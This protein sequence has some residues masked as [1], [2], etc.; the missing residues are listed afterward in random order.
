MDGMRFHASVSDH[1]A[2]HE[3]IKS[4]I[5]DAGAALKK[6][7]VAFVFFTGHHRDEATELAERLWLELDPQCIVG[8]SAEGVIGGD[9]E[10]ERAP[11]ISL[12]VGELPGVTI[13]PFHIGPDDWR[14]L[15]L[16]EP[17]ELAERVG[18]GPQ[19][20]AFIGFGDPFTTPLTQFVQA[21]DERCA[22]APLL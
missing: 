2:S 16:D 17:G 5:A 9:R 8:C 4:V 21:L 15:L 19:T 18:Y 10:I 6:I 22:G 11:G 14:R 12:L 20:R 7:D 1:E 13:P 3:A